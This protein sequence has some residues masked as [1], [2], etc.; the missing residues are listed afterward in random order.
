MCKGETVELLVDYGK[1]YEDS[2]VR[3]G[4]GLENIENHVLCDE[5]ESAKVKR[6][7]A[8]RVGIIVLIQSMTFLEIKNTLDFL[9]TRIITP[10]VL[11][12]DGYFY[13][14][15]A[16]SIGKQ[17]VVYQVKPP[18]KKQLTARYRLAWIGQLY[19]E[20]IKHMLANKQLDKIAAKKYL[21]ILD[22]N[23]L[24]PHSRL[25]GSNNNLKE[26]KEVQDICFRE[27]YE[28][29][30]LFISK[31]YGVFHAYDPSL[32]CD[33]G[34]TLCKKLIMT[35]LDL[36]RNSN[37]SEKRRNQQM[38][39]AAI[40]DIAM[41]AVASVRSHVKILH[42]NS[43][44]QQVLDSIRHLGFLWTENEAINNHLASASP[45]NADGDVVQLFNTGISPTISNHSLT[46]HNALETM[47]V[48]FN[49]G[50]FGK[51]KKKNMTL[52]LRCK[53]SSAN[54]C[55][56]NYD[57]L[58]LLKNGDIKV[59]EEWYILYQVIRIVDVISSSF[60]EWPSNCNILKTVCERT[61]VNFRNATITAAHR[62]ELG[63]SERNNE[64][65][66]AVNRLT[67]HFTSKN[68]KLHINSRSSYYALNK[69]TPPKTEADNPVVDKQRE[70]DQNL[71]RP[72]Q[73]KV[74]K[75]VLYEKSDGSLPDGWRVDHVQRQSSNHIDR[76]WYTKTGKKLRSRVEVGLFL[77]LIKQSGGDEEAAWNKFPGS[78]KKM[79]CQ[80]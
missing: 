51:S 46:L 63:E 17:N 37:G 5:V 47:C 64:E 58:T 78:R 59:D 44:K 54:K 77:D 48:S 33:L 4:Y 74:S 57:C 39:A 50:K 80:S 22:P 19:R 79:S 62:I 68:D 45:S 21:Q 24:D 1:E 66:N 65:N 55:N 25:V 72:Y 3:K 34:R 13:N 10:L 70:I 9:E 36:R 71:I 32:W 15:A 38:F 73:L 69:G 27:E 20:R 14:I 42:S 76:Y 30:L 8:D 26:I 61:G 31:E 40:Y 23:Y 11:Y 35:L 7:H 41:N 53:S 28:E 16:K 6:D 60:I 29:F 52:Q 75:R 43:S 18:S 67:S 56:D 49:P 12:T 2:R